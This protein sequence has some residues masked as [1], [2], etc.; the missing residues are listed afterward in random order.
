[1]ESADCVPHSPEWRGGCIGEAVMCGFGD[2][3][4][5]GLTSRFRLNLYMSNN[6]PVSVD[7]S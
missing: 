6:Y 1:M 2:R 7:N 3:W 5:N 4:R